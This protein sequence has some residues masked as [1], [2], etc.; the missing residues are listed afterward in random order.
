MQQLSRA[1]ARQFQLLAAS[2]SLI[3]STT[4]SGVHTGRLDAVARPIPHHEKATQPFKAEVTRVSF[5][6][7]YVPVMPSADG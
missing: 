7:P 5:T 1:L 6:M 2:S 4:L 3:D